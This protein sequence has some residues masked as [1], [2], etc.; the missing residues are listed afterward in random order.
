MRHISSKLT[1]NIVSGCIGIV[2]RNQETA[3]PFP[4]NSSWDTADGGDGS[5][6]SVQFIMG[7]GRWRRRQCRFPT[8]HHGIRQMEDTAVPFPYN[9]SW[10]TADGGHGSAVSL[11]LIMG[12][13]RWRTRQCRFPTINHGRDTALPSPNYLINLC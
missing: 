12:Y 5:A 1:G 10:D 4:Y 7:Y 8:I 2:R 3:V 11:Q 6:V 13:G 9:S